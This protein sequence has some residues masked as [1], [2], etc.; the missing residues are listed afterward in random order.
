MP[1]QAPHGLMEHAQEPGKFLLFISA[2]FIKFHFEKAL[3]ILNNQC[4]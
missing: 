3:S 4:L 1:F 2:Y